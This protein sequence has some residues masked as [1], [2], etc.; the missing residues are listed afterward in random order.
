MN[1]TPKTKIRALEFSNEG[2]TAVGIS[3]GERTF[4]SWPELTLLVVGRL[5]TNQIEVIER[6]KRGGAKP[7]DRRELST[8]ESLMDVYTRPSATGWR[9]SASNFDYGCLGSLKGF[10]TFENFEALIEALSERAPNLK[11]VQSYG[12]LRP[13]LANVWPL[14]TKTTYGG[15]R[16]SG[17]GKY[18]MSTVTATDNEAQFDNFSRLLH[19]LQAAGS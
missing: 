11:V 15:W 12:Q 17:A 16:R 5:Q 9:I 1:R 10:A 7:L 14:E 13:L 4:A 19:W 2:A 18:D 3:S 8:D 6:K